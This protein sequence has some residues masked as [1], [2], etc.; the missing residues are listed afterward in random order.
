[1]TRPS[2]LLFL[3]I[4]CI[5]LCRAAPAE[6]KRCIFSIEVTRDGGGMNDFGYTAV[7]DGIF[8]YEHADGGISGERYQRLDPNG[9]F[10][11]MPER[12]I[13]GDGPEFTRRIRD[14]FKKS[15]IGE[16]DFRAEAVAASEAYARQ[17]VA[18][19]KVFP[20]ITIF[21]GSK[22]IKIFADLEGTR[23]TIN[24]RGPELNHL[25]KSI[26][27]YNEKLKG[28]KALLDGIAYE[29]GRARIFLIH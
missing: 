8:L 13:F 2:L 25:L 28:L 20:A 9:A 22:T 27:D 5:G 7:G 12:E 15:A 14:L 11:R 3:S 23:F 26:G 18:E 21:T 10:R 29:Y 24:N 19:G 6:T 1:M 17:V 4:T 16:L